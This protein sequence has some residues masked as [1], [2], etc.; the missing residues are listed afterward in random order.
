MAYATPLRNRRMGVE[1]AAMRIAAEN[2]R[3][4]RALVALLALVAFWAQ[5]LAPAAALAAS[6][7]EPPALVICTN[8][9]V[10][11]TA[12]KAP[13]QHRKGFAG[14]PC[15]DC[16]AASLAAIAPPELTARPVVYEIAR[17]ERTAPPRL[18]RP[19]ARAPPRPLGQGPPVLNV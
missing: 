12:P 13:A 16:L 2:G 3:P 17:I 8:E 9:G 14:M 11:T 18:V 6:R 5:A 10:V 7:G 1:S 19:R 4:G 15:Q